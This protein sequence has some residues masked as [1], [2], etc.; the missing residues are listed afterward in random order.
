MLKGLSIKFNIK[1]T[2]SQIR[3]NKMNWIASDDTIIFDYKFNNK[4]D[5]S[6]ISAYTKLIFSNYT[7]NEK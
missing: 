5:I 2:F 7:L 3:Y 4:L 6:L 1:N